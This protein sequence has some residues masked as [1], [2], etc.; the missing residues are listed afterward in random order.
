MSPGERANVRAT[1]NART[2][3]RA[4]TC[5]WACCARTRK[6]GVRGLIDPAARAYTIEVVEA[7]LL[8]VQYSG[9]SLV[10]A[11]VFPRDLFGFWG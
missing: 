10:C 2:C 5:E 1:A 6:E 11:L 8:I 9:T 7:T 3:E 4:R